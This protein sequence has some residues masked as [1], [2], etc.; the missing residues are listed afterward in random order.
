MHKKN[1]MELV[2]SDEQHSFYA[3]FRQHNV[4]EENFSVGLVYKADDGS[5]LHLLRCNGPHGDHIDIDPY[6]HHPYTHVHRATEKCIAA[7]LKPD[8]YAQISVE[9]STFQDAIF[10]FI[11][12]CNIEGAEQHFR[13]IRQ[14]GQL[15]YLD[16]EGEDKCGN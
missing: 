14:P 15:C 13:F 12:T 7:G 2:S 16:P 9:Y 1:S 8:K 5:E 4:F 11:R 6:N 3:Y 10:H